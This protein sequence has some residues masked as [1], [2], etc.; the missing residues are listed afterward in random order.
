MGDIA[1]M[2]L[3]G[4]LCEICGTFLGDPIG[5]PETCD[6]CDEIEVDEEE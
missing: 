2:I 1:D 4:I 5:H 6:D 3:E